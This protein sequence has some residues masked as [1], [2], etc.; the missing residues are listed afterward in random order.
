MAFICI[1]FTDMLE[2]TKSVADPESDIK[3]AF[4]VKL[5]IQEII[6]NWNLISV[7]GSWKVFD[8]D[9]D[10]IITVSLFSF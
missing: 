7:N 5:N 8:L 9:G 6:F 3:D 4:R 2:K 1:E 10:G